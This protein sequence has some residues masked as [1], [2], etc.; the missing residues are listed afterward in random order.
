MATSSG[1]MCPLTMRARLL[2]DRVLSYPGSYA[3]ATSPATSV[4]E[5]LIA[6]AIAF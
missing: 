6:L 3:N 5:D 2:L 1:D 4:L